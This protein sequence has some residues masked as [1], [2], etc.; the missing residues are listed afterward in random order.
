MSSTSVE[1][2]GE[3]HM[4]WQHFNGGKH[5]CHTNILR[6]R[7][8][9]FQLWLAGMTDCMHGVNVVVEIDE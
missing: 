9:V 3:C 1:L 8:L 2:F 4:N 7:G 6:R 5:D